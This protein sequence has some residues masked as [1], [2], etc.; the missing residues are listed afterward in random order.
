MCYIS[1]KVTL[2]DYYCRFLK[3]EM[4]K[5]TFGDGNKLEYV[6]TAVQSFVCNFFLSLLML[7]EAA[8]I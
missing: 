1:I 6:Y 5:F 4:M 2:G 8:F 7:T 3:N